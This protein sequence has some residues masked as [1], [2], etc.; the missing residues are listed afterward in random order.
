MLNTANIEKEKR[1]MAKKQISPIHLDIFGKTI[2]LFQ[3]VLF[4]KVWKPLG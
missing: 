1:L 4:M 3:E 2:Q